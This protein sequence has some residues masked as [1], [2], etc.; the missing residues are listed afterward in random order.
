MKVVVEGDEI[1]FATKSKDEMIAL[2][3]VLR[4]FATRNVHLRIADVCWD[5]GVERLVLK[6]S[7]DKW[8]EKR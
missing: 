5:K 4:D 2:R 8:E 3:S 7:P 1:Q 6:P